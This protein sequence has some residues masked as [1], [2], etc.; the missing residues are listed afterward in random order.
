MALRMTD[1]VS[2]MT[3]AFALAEYQRINA[4]GAALKWH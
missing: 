3:D 1:H 2:G 4:M